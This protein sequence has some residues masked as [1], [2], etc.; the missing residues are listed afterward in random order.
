[1]TLSRKKKSENSTIQINPERSYPDPNQTPNS[2]PRDAPIYRKSLSSTKGVMARV[3]NIS[4][5]TAFDMDQ[6]TELWLAILKRSSYA[7]S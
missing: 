2:P 7:H 3:K 4:S 6:T 1:M 5:P